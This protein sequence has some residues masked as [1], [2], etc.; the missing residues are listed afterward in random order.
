MFIY[1][2]RYLGRIEAEM[3][4]ETEVLLGLECKL[5]KYKVDGFAM[6]KSLVTENT[7]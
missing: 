5:S 4:Y 1:L 7:M 6:M 3:I 2:I